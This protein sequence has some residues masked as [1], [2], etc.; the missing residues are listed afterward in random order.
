MHAD[1]L[2]RV[3]WPRGA[4]ADPNAVYAELSGYADF[5]PHDAP[6]PK[7]PE[8]FPV[9]LEL[10]DRRT[11]A[12]LRRERPDLIVPEAYPDL[13]R[14]ATA[15][16]G[17]AAYLDLAA[18][19]WGGLVSRWELQLPVIPLRPAA[20]QAHAPGLR[21][22]PIKGEM[23]KD[24]RLESPAGP[25]EK[26]EDKGTEV[27]LGVIDSGCPYAHARL[28]RKGRTRLLAL[29]HQDGQTHIPGETEPAGFGYGLEVGRGALNDWLDPQGSGACGAT[30]EARCYQRSGDPFLRHR[31]SHGAAVLDLFAGS[32]PRAARYPRD[33]AGTQHPP[34]WNPAR[35]AASRA[36]IVF[37]QLPL[38]VVDDSSSA[39]L[40]RHLLDGLRYIVSRRTAQTRRIVVNI[41]DGTSRSTHDGTSLIE[42]AM[43]ALIDE[44]RTQH[45][46]D[47]EI[48]L[49][50]GNAQL[51]ARHAVIPLAEAGPR[52]AWLRVQPDCERPSFLHLRVP[53]GVA[54]RLRLHAPARLGAASF[55]LGPGECVTWN[56]AGR[57][58][59]WAVYPPHGDGLR[60]TQALIVWAPTVA[61]RMA[62][63]RPAPCGDWRIEVVGGRA[64]QP[65]HLWVSMNQ[66]NTIGPASARQ[67]RFIDAD[68][69]YDPHRYLRSEEDADPLPLSVIRRLGSLNGLATATGPGLHVVGS[70][71]MRHTGRGARRS[72]YSSTGPSAG[73]GTRKDVDAMEVADLARVQPGIRAAGSL[74]GQ[75]VIVTGTSFAAPQYARRLANRRKPARS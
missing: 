65:L 51:D 69:R 16:P 14:Y 18:T 28:L 19:G 46:I 41:S 8:E 15:R 48:V 33:S 23:R 5:L 31:F 39:A 30:H 72:P 70:R 25:A 6:D 54:P 56:P 50:A 22:A 3:S 45:R 10:A 13:A 44:A 74:S 42:Q 21:A 60:P 63:R 26:Q 34:S 43:L 52:D 17:R 36:D 59:L 71:L 32:L 2:E 64:T 47:L 9:I 24:P 27:L 7:P 37:V 62:P 73:A 61:S 4:C 1:E 49:A 53:P 58:C 29:W 57:A 12:D 67:A 66:K 68:G 20:S 55:E 35:D 75:T 38:R 40:P 11:L